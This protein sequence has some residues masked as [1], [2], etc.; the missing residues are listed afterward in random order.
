[1]AKMTVQEIR[2]QLTKLS[3]EL[4]NLRFDATRSDHDHNNIKHAEKAVDTAR[5]A[6]FNCESQS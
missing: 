2:Q 5:R 6:L 1:M 4:E 3:S